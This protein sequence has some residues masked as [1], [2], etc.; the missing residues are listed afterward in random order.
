[1]LSFFDLCT[2][3]IWP[4]HN[5]WHR[6]SPPLSSKYCT[7]EFQDTTLSCFHPIS[8][9]LNLFCWVILIPLTFYIFKTPEL[10]LQTSF[11]STFCSYYVI[12]VVLFSFKAKDSTLIDLVHTSYLK[13]LVSV[14]FFF[15]ILYAFWN[16][17]EKSFCLFSISFWLNTSFIGTVLLLLTHYFSESLE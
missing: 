10:I 6:R 17:I 16:I 15:Q 12:L 7:I 3:C 4:L 1:M 13:S 9:F 11:L 8:L 5:F 2:H 14:L